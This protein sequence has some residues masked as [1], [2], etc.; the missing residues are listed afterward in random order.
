MEMN[1]RQFLERSS[2][3]M[4]TGALGAA[5]AMGSEPAARPGRKY[6]LIATEE[7]FSIPE[8]TDEFRRIAKIAY[9]NPDLDMWRSFLDPAPNAPPLLRRLLDLEG[10][11]IQIMDQAGVDMHLLSLT[12]PGVQMFDTETATSLATVANDRLAEVIQKH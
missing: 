4:A 1:R 9:S 7:A 11:R 12:S 2:A 10:E 3:L 5:A 6:R 8:Q